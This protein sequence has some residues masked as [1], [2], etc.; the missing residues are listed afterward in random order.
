MKKAPLLALAVVLTGCFTYGRP[1]MRPGS[2]VAL[3][4]PAT[5]GDV[6]A[7]AVLCSTGVDTDTTRVKGQSCPTAAADSSPKPAPLPA[8]K[9]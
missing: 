1:V 5:V 6:V 7:K 3:S 2:N 9:P 4:K 8:K